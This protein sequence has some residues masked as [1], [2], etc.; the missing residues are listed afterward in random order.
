MANE[1]NPSE[2]RAM[3]WA[4]IGG[5]AVVIG[6]T[7][8]VGLAVW[9]ATS[10]L[11]SDGLFLAGFVVACAITALGLY[12]LIAEFIGGIGPLRFPLPPTRHEREGKHALPIGSLPSL[13]SS[14][15]GTSPPAHAPQIV[16]VPTSH[17]Q[18]GKL[19]A[20]QS[21]MVSAASPAPEGGQSS[22]CDTN[23]E[24]E[25]QLVALYREGEQ[26]RAHILL[27]GTLIPGD[28]I[29]GRASQ[30]QVEREQSARDWDG[31]VLD[32]LTGDAREIWAAAG[33]LP[34]KKLDY[35]TTIAGAREFLAKKLD[36]LREIIA[37]SD[38]EHTS[39]EA[40]EP[41]PRAPAE[42]SEREPRPPQRP[43]EHTIRT[44]EN[45]AR[46]I[47]QAELEHDNSAPST[48]TR[49]VSYNLLAAVESWG[50]ASGATEQA[51]Q[52]SG[53]VGADLARLNAFVAKELAR[54]RAEPNR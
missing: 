26:L 16:H 22:P 54:L 28:L 18:A 23:Q 41:S 12:A 15:A 51:P 40:R 31:R 30:R 4:S 36:C 21:K 6:A 10:H 25:Q 39:A 19:A 43:V 3:A 20:Q 52:Y 24:L 11:W 46:L 34:V 14:G 53:D 8:G 50:R 29:H 48:E 37:G 49:R 9:G 45:F 13:L 5:A 35:V 2:H 32:V 7:A 1:P 33:T 47:L 38:A 42:G 27:S 44:G 17:Y